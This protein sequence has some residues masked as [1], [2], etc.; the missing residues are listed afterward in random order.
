MD[1]K[2]E[3]LHNRAIEETSIGTVKPGNGDGGENIA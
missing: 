3:S 1:T 2:V